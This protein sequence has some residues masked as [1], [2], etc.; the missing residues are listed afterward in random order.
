M[1]SSDLGTTREHASAQSEGRALLAA[2]AAGHI[3]VHY[4]P[5]V[6]LADG[7]ARGAEALVRW[8]H[9]AQGLLAPDGFLPA[10]ELSGAIV[11]LGRWVLARACTDAA[12]WPASADGARR[13]VNVNASGAELAA[14]GYLQAVADALHAA[15]LPPDALVLEITEGLIDLDAPEVAAALRGLSAL[16][17]RLAVDDFG[18]GYSS[19][20]RLARLDAAVLKIDRSFVTPIPASADGTRLVTGILGLAAT[21]GLDIVAEGVETT[22]QASW[23]RR[24]GCPAA[25][26]HLYSAALPAAEFTAWLRQRDGGVPDRGAAQRRRAGRP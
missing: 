5:V 25:Q 21:L 14:P 7:V 26:G 4:Q 22:E 23:L 3:E 24:A 17:V 9:P 19:L 6:A 13:R 12:G 8:R 18:T 15:H 1:C 11:E 20:T 2:L 16:G 10:A